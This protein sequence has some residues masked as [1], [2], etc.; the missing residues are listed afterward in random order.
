MKV[1]VLHAYSALNA[2][3]GLL[4]D[5][6]LDI[7]HEAFGSDLDLTIAASDTESFAYTGA[8]LL[9]SKPTR[10]GYQRAYLSEL[11]RL[12][13][14]DMVIAVGGGYQR[15]GHP[16]ELAKAGL[17]HGPQ[18]LAAAARGRGVVYLPQSI[19]PLRYGVSLPVRAALARIE[20]VFVRD[21]RSLHE[22]ERAGVV[23]APDMALL[24]DDWRSRPGAPDDVPVL[25]VR[26]VR[27]AVPPDVV[28]LAARLGTFDGYVQSQTGGNDD[29]APMHGLNP[30][31]VL[32][33]ATLIED[34]GTPRRVVVAMRLHGALMALRAGHLVIHLA[35]ERKGYGAFQDLGLEQYVHNS[36]RFDPVVVEKQV[37]SL[38][39]DEAARA[40]Y[41]QAVTAAR[42][43]FGAERQV[44]VDAVRRAA[45]GVGAPR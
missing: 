18:L 19:G 35:Y 36:F 28:A 40:D 16:L 22:L 32:P 43:G 25:S 45:S 38:L 3:D 15:A 4:V 42:A 10:R 8:R 17:V 39:D 37:R 7:L 6:C 20:T 21:P 31:E 14:Y 30:R 24:G 5:E 12:R 23:R 41:E 33:R 26:A 13:D 27:G 29:T 2:G 11:F 34:V 44:V 1:F 9:C